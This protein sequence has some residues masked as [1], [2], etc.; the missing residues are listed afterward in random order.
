MFYK[1]VAI[2]EG[3]SKYSNLNIDHYSL[4][5]LADS[6]GYV[7]YQRSSGWTGFDVVVQKY[8]K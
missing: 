2:K 1:V 3:N 5:T 8:D 4:I 7:E 6:S